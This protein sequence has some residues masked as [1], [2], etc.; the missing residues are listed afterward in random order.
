M[1][2]MEDPDRLAQ[3]L[4]ESVAR[5]A[6]RK[7]VPHAV[8]GV[9]RGDG[10]RWTGAVGEARPGGPPL[11]ADTPFFIASVTKLY[12]A[13][14]V[15]KLHEGGQVRLGDPISRYLPG[16]LTKGLHRLGGVDRTEEITIRHLLGHA[17]GLPDYL[18]ERLPGGRSLLERVVEEDDRS[19]DIH[20]IV[21]IVRSLRPHF[22]PQPL[23]EGRHRIRYSDTNYLL[24]IA[25]IEAVTGRPQHEAFEQLL[26][27]PLHLGHT[28]LPGHSEPKVPPTGDP[29]AIWYRDRPLHIPQAL[30]SF[31]DLYSTLDDTILFLRALVRGE[32]FE[33]PATLGLMTS[34]WIRFGFPRDMA[35]LRAP[36]WPIRYGLGMMRF[37]FRIPRVRT[38]GGEL[39]ELIGH[40][41]STGSWLFWC[42]QLDLF[43]SGTVD[44]ATAGALPFRFVPRLLRLIGRAAA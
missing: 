9:E 20:D 44:Q 2:P 33:D 13:A 40:S 12:I 22:P 35:A 5:L 21:R 1:E 4:D 42:P 19:W 25:V 37:R 28:W 29:A 6:A 10:F 27:R 34:R 3:R 23:R 43:L 38:P 41:G 31:R 7:R 11:R 39:P 30:S 24:L 32:V 36:G 17:S 8:V 15:M 26:F 18:E 14:V 16:E